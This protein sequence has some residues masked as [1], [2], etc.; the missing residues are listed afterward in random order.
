MKSLLIDG[1]LYLYGDVGDPWGFGDGFT[2][3]A[4]AE[5]LAEHGPGDLSVRINSGGGIATDGMAIHSLLTTHPGDVSIV[6]DGI[7]ASAASLIAMAGKS[8]EMRDGAIMMIHDPRAITFGDVETHKAAALR[9]DKLAD[10]YARVYSNRSGLT[11]A[12]VRELMKAETWLDADEAIEQG[13]ATAKSGEPAR[14]KA[15]FDYRIYARAPR[16]LPLR[17]A[18]NLAAVAAIT[19]EETMTQAAQKAAAEVTAADVAAVESSD[20]AQP[21]VATEQPKPRKDK[22]WAANFYAVAES[23]GLALGELNAIVAASDSYDM[24]KDK[25]IDALSTARSAN[26]P[27]PNG[28]HIDVLRDEAETR[29]IGMEHALLAQFSGHAPQDERA[30]PFMD[31]GVVDMAAACVGWRGSR[32]T[33]ADRERI[34]AAAT[35]TTSDFPHIFENALNKQLAARYRDATPTYRT[36]SRRMSFA[37]FRPH[38]VVNA[39]DF[40]E[41]REIL[42]GG[43]IQY[44]T[45]GEKREAVAVKSYAVAVRVSRQMLIND[46]MG[47]IAQVIADQGR[48]AARFEDKTFY[49]MMFSG[50]NADG[51]T[52]AET[53][54]QVFNT[55]D[56]SKASTP[57]TID[58]TTLSVARA[59]LRKRKSVDGSPLSVIGRYLLVGP[60][61]ET[62]AQQIV[63]PIQAQ[64]AGNV[65]PFSG[66]M[67]VV[68]TPYITGNSWY[69]LADPA[70]GANFIHGFL[71]GY[72]APRMRM[73]EP[74]GQQGMAFSLE[75]DFGVGAVDHRFGFKNAG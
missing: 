41:M 55:T 71:T 70:D 51:P 40:P 75:H 57:G 44:G 5:A 58:L 3:Q 27:L 10:N 31:M 52:L 56:S 15:A 21:V 48:A 19:G 30:R 11:A 12:Q 32:R 63:A 17:V 9:L 28:G 23:S 72:E 18:P 7:A 1:T 54:R 65:N 66:T 45:F 46:E 33:V 73:D 14:D 49:A 37:D 61:R 53:T 8:I 26:K 36:I 22:A 62:V 59:S 69:L 47:A 25:L 68:V 60:D 38:P 64:Q 34:L 29:R 43:E 6:V 42:E 24:A 4:V 35:H 74:F 50:S 16:E 39:G 20:T 13:F 67:S 2:P